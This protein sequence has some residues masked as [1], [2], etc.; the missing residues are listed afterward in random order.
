MLSKKQTPHIC[1]YC[2]SSVFHQNTAGLLFPILPRES[3]LKSKM[4]YGFLRIT[5][6]ICIQKFY[7]MNVKIRVTLVST[8]SN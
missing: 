6:K 8:L 5:L 1:S 3:I 2:V 4:D 7:L